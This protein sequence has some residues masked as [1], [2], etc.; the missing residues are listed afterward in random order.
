MSEHHCLEKGTRWRIVGRLE[1]GQSQAQVAREFSATPS[2]VSSLWS[3][4]QNSGTVSRRTGQGRPRATMPN[5]DQYLVLTAKR[6]RTSTATQ[7]SRGLAA[8]ISFKEDSCQE[9]R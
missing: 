8:A 6:H 1:A 3:Q 2:V 4:F 9:A 7:L 5:E